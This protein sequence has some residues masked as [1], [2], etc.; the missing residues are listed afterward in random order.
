MAPLI[1]LIVATLIF[2]AVGLKVRK[3]A[4]WRDATRFGVAVMFVFTSISHFSPMKHE[5][6]A[7]IPPPLPNGLWVIYVTGVLELVGAIG[8]MTR[9]FHKLAGICLI[10]LMIT[11]FPA[12]VYAAVNELQLRGKV[13][14]P[15]IPRT[16]LQLLWIGLTW[17]SAVRA[18]GQTSKTTA[19]AENAA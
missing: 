16:L 6:A 10:L 11:M 18:P 12:N 17:W 5:M 19:P 2:R 3:F 14:T 15:L 1:V 8:L 9:R 13:A 4:S 7:M